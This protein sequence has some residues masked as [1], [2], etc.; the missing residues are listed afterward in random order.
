M[1]PWCELTDVFDD[2]WFLDC[3]LDTAMQR[4]YTRQTRNG[5]PPEV[6]RARVAGNDR[7]NGELVQST[8]SRAHLVVPNLPFKAAAPER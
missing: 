8:K 4:V 3:D 6:S 7:P 5:V 1:Q 2:S